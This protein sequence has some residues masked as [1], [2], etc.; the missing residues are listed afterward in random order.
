MLMRSAQLRLRALRLLRHLLAVMVLMLS[1][2]WLQ[3]W[4]RHSQWRLLL[5]L[6]LLLPPH[7]LRLLLLLRLLWWLMLLLQLLRMLTTSTER[8]RAFFHRLQRLPCIRQLLSHLAQFDSLR[9]LA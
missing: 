2:L 4:L 5:L 9:I 6:R 1:V 3:P 8:G 7:T